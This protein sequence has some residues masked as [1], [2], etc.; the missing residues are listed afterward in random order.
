MKAWSDTFADDAVFELPFAPAAYP[1]RLVGKAAIHEYVKDYAKHIDLQRFLDITVHP[2][3]DPSTLVVE[4]EVEGRVT[5]NW[6]ALPN[7][8]VWVYTEGNGKIVRQRDYWNPSA[9]IDALG[10]D[11]TMRRT[12]NLTS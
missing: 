11:A 9:V 5:A 10:G 4:A 8:Y 7:Y 3:Q 12:F 1:Q 2:T 6:P